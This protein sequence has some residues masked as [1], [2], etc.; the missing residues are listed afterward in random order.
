MTERR[1]SGALLNTKFNFKLSENTEW[2]G[3]MAA[4]IRNGDMK[5]LEDLS[6]EYLILVEATAQKFRYQG[7]PHLD[8]VN[9]GNL[10]LIKACYNFDESK[11]FAF[12]N[13][14]YCCIR[15]AIQRAL[16]EQASIVR[17]P[18][19]QI[20]NLQKVRDAFNKLEQQFEREPSAWEI[21][22][23][24]CEKPEMIVDSMQF[25]RG[26]LNQR[27]DINPDELN[28]NCPAVITFQ[29]TTDSKLIHNSV[30][31]EIEYS[32][33]VLSHREAAIIR[34]FYGLSPHKGP[35]SIDRISLTLGISKE[36]V[37]KQKESALKKLR[38][39]CK[40]QLLQAYLN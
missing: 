11:G 12:S 20:G 33:S 29:E 13:Y 18:H 23:L 8:L 10:G 38:K 7:L 30:I 19:N 39:A 4:R 26:N 2:E 21:S 37:K 1:S 32:L 25:T 9:E 40:V 3:Q 16:A 24:L 6:G 22:E 17:L 27:D 36:F 15:R 31:E 14:A 35:A 34:L 5:A 28:P